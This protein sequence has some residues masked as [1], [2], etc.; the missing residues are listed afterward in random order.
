MRYRWDKDHALPASGLFV[1]PTIIELERAADLQEEVFGPILHVVRFRAH[2]LHKL[3]DDIESNGTGL[4]LGIHSRIDARVERRSPT[5][6]RTAMS[7][8]TAT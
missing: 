7:T 8:S 3:L 4:T 2:E 6:S 5:G 1:P